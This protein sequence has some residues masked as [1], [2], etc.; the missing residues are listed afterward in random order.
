[1]I[2]KEDI[3]MNPNYKELS[4]VI[5]TLMHEVKRMGKE[6]FLKFYV[7]NRLILKEKVDFLY[8]SFFLALLGYLDSNYK[9]IEPEICM[10]KYILNP[11]DYDDLKYGVDVDL[12]KLF[13]KANDSLRRRGFL[14]EEIEEAV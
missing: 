12:V 11:Y 14:F 1:M 4:F 7:K 9:N 2:K 10:S 13:N 5:S 6:E 3:D 8:Y